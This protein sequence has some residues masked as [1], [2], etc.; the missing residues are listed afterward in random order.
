[1]FTLCCRTDQGL[2]MSKVTY[3][4]ETLTLI[5]NRSNIISLYSVYNAIAPWV[6]EMWTI[7]AS[8]WLAC[9]SWT[10]PF[11]LT[12]YISDRMQ[13]LPAC[14]QWRLGCSEEAVTL[15]GLMVSIK[16]NGLWV[17]ALSQC[18]GGEGCRLTYTVLLHFSW[19][20]LCSRQVGRRGRVPWL[21]VA[22]KAECLW[23]LVVMGC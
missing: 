23:P 18:V 16:Q 1:M 19:I 12:L 8:H 5:W 6:L 2:H 7:F 9:S 15:V 21:L 14:W 13:W 3:W 17:S 20:I 10:A 4:V 22:E 11:S